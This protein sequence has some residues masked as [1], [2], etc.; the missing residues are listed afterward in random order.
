MANSEIRGFLNRK[1]LEKKNVDLAAANRV[2][3]DAL[4]AAPQVHASRVYTREQLL[5]GG[6]GDFITTAAVNGFHQ[7]RSGDLIIVFEPYHIPGSGSRG[8]TTHFMP[9]NYD[10]HVP[11]VFFGAGVKHGVYHRTIA[12]N[13]IV[14]TLAAML[15]VELPS[16]AFGRVLTEIVP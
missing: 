11:V 5:G 3:A 13:D 1:T 7:S 15:D 9:Y 6:L 12:V 16:G 10:N 8:G 14:P 4:L 2:A